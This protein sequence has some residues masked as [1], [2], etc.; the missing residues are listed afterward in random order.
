MRIL[1]FADLHLGVETY[2]HLDPETGLNTRVKD[3]SR[4][5][6]AVVDCAVTRGVDLVLFCG[7][8]YKTCDP[9]PTHQ[10]EFAAQLRRL[11]KRGI[12]TVLIAGNHDIPTAHGK[13]ISFDIFG[14][15]E[16]EGVT[17]V[18][19]PGLLRLTTASGP[20]EIAA[21]PWPTRHL[22]RASEEFREHSQE[23]L[24]TTI[25]E[26]CRNQIE[27]FA[28]QSDPAVPTVLAA[29]L[30]AAEATFSGSERPA[31]IGPDPTLMTSALAQ[32]EFD[33]VALGHVHKHQNLNNTGSLPVVYAGS[34]ERVDFGEERDNK[35]FCLVDITST[36]LERTTTYEFI[37]L[38][39]RNFLTVDVEI[40]EGEDTTARIVQ[41]LRMHDLGEVILRIRCHLPAGPVTNIDMSTVG[42]IAGEAHF[43]AGVFP[44]KPAIQRQ[45]RSTVTEEMD[46]FDALNRYINNL[47]Q[48]HSR[49][50]LLLNHA[51]QIESE[52]TTT[53]DND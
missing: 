44:I 43:F 50:E 18:R 39:A 13:A 38:P 33:Y 16:L 22:L 2:G 48:L 29:H 34:L 41:E 11:C 3:F 46:M 37:I 20:L 15:L 4:S 14:T 19:R 24:R 10:R 9:S 40:A 51:A 5:L 26:I 25:E 21:L 42:S 31:V 49:R 52:L 27:Q 32:R 47:P 53:E 1:H 23:N 36:G 28:R 17:V 45:R 6:A 12:P 8:A 7:D 30:A 35:G